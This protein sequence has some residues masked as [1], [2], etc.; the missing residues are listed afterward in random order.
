MMM[1]IL[2]W[3]G[4]HMKTQKI[5]KYIQKKKKKYFG[6]NIESLRFILKCEINQNV[7]IIP[8]EY[9][10]KK[11]KVGHERKFLLCVLCVFIRIAADQI[12]CK[13]FMKRKILKIGNNFIFE[14]R[15]ASS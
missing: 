6:I 14:I 5:E 10:K 9:S 8:N 1:K 4:L 2:I 15:L 13:F 11:Y 12:V 3:N 7:V